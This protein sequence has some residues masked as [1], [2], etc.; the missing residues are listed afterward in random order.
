MTEDRKLSSVNIV[1][2]PVRSSERPSIEL[3]TRLAPSRSLVETLAAEAGGSL[4]DARA[5]V[6]R[7]FLEQLR[8]LELGCG[9]AD[10]LVK[11]RG[12]VDAHIAHATVVCRAYQ[13]AADRMVALEVRKAQSDYVPPHLRAALNAARAEWRGMAIAARTAADAAIGAA[14]AL[15]TFIREG[16]G[17]SPVSAGEPRQ[18][19]LF[20]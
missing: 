7:E 16:M 17:D 19:V 4:H 11:V 9:N 20:A 18:L 1:A 8:A 12:L 10:A 15:T 13:D 5:G 3:V 6:C 2:L 14:T